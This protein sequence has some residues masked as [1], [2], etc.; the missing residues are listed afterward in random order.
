MK[1]ITLLSSRNILVRS[2]VDSEIKFVGGLSRSG[3]RPC[4]VVELVVEA[5]K[6]I[7]SQS[8][9]EKQWSTSSGRTTLPGTFSILW[10]TFRQGPDQPCKPTTPRHNNDK[11]R[12]KLL[13][14][15][16]AL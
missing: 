6:A 2:D 8:L 4:P 3:S 13:A 9:K 15:W 12:Q 5:E 14:R 11:S 10:G 16:L 1:E 7:T